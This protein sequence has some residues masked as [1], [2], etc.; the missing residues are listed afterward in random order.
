MLKNVSLEVKR[1]TLVGI[2][3]HTGSGKS[4]L[5]N[6]LCRFYET[7]QGSVEI[8]GTDIRRIPMD[9]YR[10]QVGIVPQ[11]PF[12]FYGGIAENIAFG[13][14]DATPA[15][16]VEAAVWRWHTSSFCACRTAMTRPLVNGV[17]RCRVENVSVWR[18]PE[19]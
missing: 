11:D 16:V 4:T 8:D 18:L 1:Q 14:H 2:V 10:A 3:G 15:K 9:D 12:L 6:L 13:R 19:R 7:D 5:A 17:N